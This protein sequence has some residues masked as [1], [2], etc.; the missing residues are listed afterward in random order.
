MV[1]M[2]DPFTYYKDQVPPQ[3]GIA[4]ITPADFPQNALVVTLQLT[5]VLL[6]LAAVALICCFITTVRTARW[7]LLALAAADLGHI[8]SVYVGLG[9]DAFWDYASWNG[10]T[11]G[12][13]GASAF[14]H[15]NRLLTVLGAFGALGGGA[16]NT[17]AAAGK[18]TN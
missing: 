16:H 1:G 18:K 13:V 12:N 15:V 17:A 2:S 9:P 11:L 14:L 8:Y 5:N 6:L 4:D 7:Y 3:Q 10:M